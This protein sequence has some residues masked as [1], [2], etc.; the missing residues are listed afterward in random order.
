[1][2]KIKILWYDEFWGKLLLLLTVCIMVVP[3]GVGPA[4]LDSE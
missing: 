3:K 2:Y 4:E 1:M